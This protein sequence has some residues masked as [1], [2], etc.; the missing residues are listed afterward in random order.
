MNNQLAKSRDFSFEGHDIRTVTINGNPWFF[1]SDVCSAI[2]LDN[3]AIRKLDDDEKGLHS[4]QTH[5]GVQEVSVISESGLYT[6]I[7]RCRDA[8][9]HGTLPWRFRKWVTNDVLPSIRKTG[10][11]QEKSQSK[12]KKPDSRY[13][14]RLIIRDDLMGTTI[15][16]NGHADSLRDVAGGISTDLGFKP[17]AFTHIPI[18]RDKIRRLY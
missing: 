3:T 12:P 4:T 8:I 9:K 2:S 11:Y 1:A 17:N 16:L 14:A 15:E 18:A 5:G 13:Y 7:L 6:L 10:T